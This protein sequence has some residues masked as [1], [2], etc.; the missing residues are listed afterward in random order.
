MP[1]TVAPDLL[2]QVG[3][4][5][6]ELTADGI[7]EAF[8]AIDFEQESGARYRIKVYPDSQHAFHADHR[9]SYNPTTAVE[10]RI[11]TLQWFT[12]HLGLEP[13]TMA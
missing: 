6:N 5:T 1:L 3:P 8:R 7:R 13:M 11:D 10:A 4:P 2:S 12:E 9:A